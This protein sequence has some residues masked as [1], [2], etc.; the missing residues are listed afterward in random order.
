MFR[1]IAS[2]EG[3]HYERYRAAAERLRQSR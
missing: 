2:D 3:D 1:Q